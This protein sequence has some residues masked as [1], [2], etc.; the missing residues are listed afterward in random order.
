MLL[1]CQNVYDRKLSGTDTDYTPPELY[2][3][4]ASA[5]KL[6]VAVRTT[7]G[8]GT[9]PKVTVALEHSNDSVNWTQ[10]TSLASGSVS[11]AGIDVYYGYDDGT[12]PLGTFAR[13]AV[14]LTGTNPSAHVSINLCGRGRPSAA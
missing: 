2:R 13:L 10:K 4:V 11:A 3:L 9:S 1:F 8:G 12:E 6:L 14:S 5:C 7:Q